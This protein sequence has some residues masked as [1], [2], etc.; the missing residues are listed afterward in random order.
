VRHEK[1]NI[2]VGK[3]DG[4]RPIGRPRRRWE[5]YIRMDLRETGWRVWTRLIWLRIGISGGIV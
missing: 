1:Y 3:N 5:D 4:K 2:L